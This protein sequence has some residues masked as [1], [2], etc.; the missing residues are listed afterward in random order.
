LTLT[1]RG[2]I[3]TYKKYYQ[4]TDININ[5]TGRNEHVLAIEQTICTMKEQIGAIANQLPFEAYPHRLIIEMVYNVTFWL[6][7]FHTEM[8]YT[9]K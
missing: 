9:T 2:A 8:V 1:W 7:F 5:V 3:Q 4:D 6:N